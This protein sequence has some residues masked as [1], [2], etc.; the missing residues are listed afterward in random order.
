MQKF[1]HCYIYKIN[2]TWSNVWCERV[3]GHDNVKIVKSNTHLWLLEHKLFVFLHPITSSFHTSILFILFSPLFFNLL[4]YHIEYINCK[5]ETEKEIKRKNVVYIFYNYFVHELKSYRKLQELHLLVIT[6][7][8]VCISVGW[9][10]LF[11]KTSSPYFDILF[12][13]DVYW[14]RVWA[15]I[16]KFLKPTLLVLAHI[17]KFKNL[18]A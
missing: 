6:P 8:D 12:F 4:W 14:M 10:F 2:E 16:F 11:E 17:F 9:F 18:E 3:G 7:L 1:L 5:L 13:G 15:W